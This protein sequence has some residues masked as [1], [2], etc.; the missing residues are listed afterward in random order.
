M[1]IDGAGEIAA[2]DELIL[3]AGR[4]SREIG[5]AKLNDAATSTAEILRE[6]E[7][8]L[9]EWQSQWDTYAKS[10]ADAASSSRSYAQ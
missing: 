3:Q 5:L 8:K 2:L 10:S 6:A 4:G 7:V 9:A 1:P